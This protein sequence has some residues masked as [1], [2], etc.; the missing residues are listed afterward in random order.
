MG[1][2]DLGRQFD[3]LAKKMMT[4]MRSAAQ[5]QIRERLCRIRCDEHGSFANVALTGSDP[6]E[7]RFEI[8]GCCE[9]LKA[10]VERELLSSGA[11]PP[12]DSADATEHPDAEDVL[13]NARPRAFLSHATADKARFVV[14]LDALLRDRGIAVWLDDRELLP[15]KNLV[16]EIFEAGLGKSD[17]VIAVLS[18]NSIDRPWVQA[19]LTTAVVRQIEGRV[20]AL[21]PVILDGVAPP[22]SVERLVQLR[23]NDLSNIQASVDR[24]VAAVFGTVPA[25]VADPPAYTA[26]P[27]HGLSGLEADDERVF[28]LACERLLESGN[29]HPAI[30]YESVIDDAVVSG[31]S[32]ELVRESIAMLEQQH[33]FREKF[34]GINE[35][36]LGARISSWALERYLMTYRAQEYDEARVRIISSIVNDNVGSIEQIQAMGIHYFI[37]AH[38]INQLDLDGHLITAGGG[39]LF[40][41]QPSLTRVLRK[42]RPPM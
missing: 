19:E 23:I 18:A 6:D 14:E 10:K 39:M 31:M 21:I 29:Q 37:G 3:R 38:V 32:A 16:N 13:S 15:G 36:W 34:G 26:I 25:P 4:Q 24:I 30:G 2:G 7:M 17:I 42:L 9:K 8:R 12:T 35:G 28:V 27:V 5:E 40:R 22:V 20:K 33:Y 1:A 11:V 41:A